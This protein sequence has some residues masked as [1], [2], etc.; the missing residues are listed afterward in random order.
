MI[1]SFI[2]SQFPV[3]KIS[4]ES[5][6]ERKA[7]SGQTLTGLG[8]WWGRKPLILV[9]AT[10]LGLLMPKSEEPEIDR[11]IFLKI[12]TMDD[13]GLWQ[14]KNKK[15]KIEEVLDNL[16]AGEKVKYFDS[17]E[18]NVV[19]DWKNHLRKEEK[20]EVEKMAFSRLN[21]DDQLTYCLRPEQV[22][23]PSPEAWKEI[24]KHLRTNAFSLQELVEELGQREFGNTPRVGD[25]FAGGGSIPFEAARIGCEAYASDLN[26]AAA[27]LTWASLNIIGGGKEVF[28][29]NIIFS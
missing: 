26:P 22:D 6:K 21:Y 20:E 2:E 3:S 28:V 4:K 15:L 12:L 13:E 27:L 11:E 5:Y 24:N 19:W 9:R 17:P 1:N 16:T 10:I 7:V 8:K 14:R 25:A 23:G 18:N 29:I